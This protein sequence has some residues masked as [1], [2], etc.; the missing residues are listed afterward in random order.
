LYEAVLLICG[1]TGVSVVNP[2]LQEHI[3]LLKSNELVR[4]K[5]MQLMFSA[6]ESSFIN[7]IYTTELKQARDRSDIKMEF[8]VTAKGTR[9]VTE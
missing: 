2:Y 3:S 9:K 1:G 5:S 6:K 4:T 8:F 7:Q